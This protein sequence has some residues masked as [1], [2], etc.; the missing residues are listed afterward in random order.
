MIAAIYARKSTEQTGVADE[1]PGE[2]RSMSGLLVVALL[3]WVGGGIAVYFWSLGG[4]WDAVGKWTQNWALIMTLLVV[5]CYTRYTAQLVRL[6]RKSQA[7]ERETALAVERVQADWDA[8]NVHFYVRNVGLSA[9]HNAVILV[10][11]GKGFN[12]TPLGSLGRD[13]KLLL[14]DKVE[15]HF[16]D[17]SEVGFVIAAESAL[18]ER[19]FVTYGFYGVL[20]G[21]PEFWL[22][23][24]IEQVLFKGNVL[25]YFD[26]HF[27]EFEAKLADVRK[28]TVE[29]QDEQPRWRNKGLE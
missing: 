29:R 17:D 22:R 10:R 13:N 9:A 2:G 3:V 23:Q 15:K 4:R 24:Q 16:R 6:S 7:R 12:E 1:M 21:S 14:P 5:W 25:D 19:V 27:Q 20:A 11:D 8:N 28:D 26:L 18:P